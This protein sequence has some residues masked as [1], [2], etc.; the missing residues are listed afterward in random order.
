M[1]GFYFLSFLL[2]MIVT[3]KTAKA[4]ISVRLSKTVT[5]LSFPGNA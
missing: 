5:R 4:I 3:I 2:F 1:S